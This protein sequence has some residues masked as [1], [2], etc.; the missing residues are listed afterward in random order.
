LFDLGDEKLI[1]VDE[2]NRTT[3]TAGKASIHRRALPSKPFAPRA[4]GSARNSASAAR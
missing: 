2:R 3:G 4:A 1:L